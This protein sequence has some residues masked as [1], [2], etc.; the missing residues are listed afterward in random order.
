MRQCILG[1]FPQARDRTDRNRE[2]P[3]SGS[4]ISVQN[5]NHLVIR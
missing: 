5:A 4:Q 1:K 3:R 2:G